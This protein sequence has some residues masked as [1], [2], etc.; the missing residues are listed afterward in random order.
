MLITNCYS[1]FLSL[2][3]GMSVFLQQ[4]DDGGV[5]YDIFRMHCEPIDGGI[6][7]SENLEDGIM[8]DK[9]LLLDLFGEKYASKIFGDV[10]DH[11]LIELDD[12]NANEMRD[13]IEQFGRAD[14][15]SLGIFRKML[16]ALQSVNR[17]KLFNLLSVAGGTT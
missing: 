5:E 2:D 1:K 4:R 13:A 3:N 17:G 6:L 16:G 14:A 10:E 15:A 12:E 9:H 11:L 7:E 8:L